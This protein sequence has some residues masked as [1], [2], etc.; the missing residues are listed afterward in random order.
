MDRQDSPGRSLTR[1]EPYGRDQFLSEMQ[2]FFGRFKVKEDVRFNV[3]SAEFAEGSED[4]GRAHLK[5]FVVGRDGQGRREWLKGTAHVA[6]TKVGGENWR[7]REL[8]LETLASKVSRTDLFSEVALPAGVA[9]VFPTFGTGKNQG[10]VSHGAAVA[11]VNGDGLLDLAV[12]GVDRN[13]LYVNDGA[14]GFRDTSSES[15]I[16]FAP[17]GSGVL[18][19]DYDND[20]DSDLFMA[21]VG[22]QVLFE[23]RW[24]PDGELRFWDVSEKAGVDRSAVGFS[25]V[26]ADVNADGYPDIYVAS[27]NHYGTVM[28]DSWLRATN[29][30]PNL[31][32]INGGDG[33]F[34]EAGGAWNVGDSRWSYA[35]GFVRYRSRR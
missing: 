7:L 19:L 9:G 10:F 8:E 34:Q 24:I 3:K 6:V 22:P 13:R 15:L 16:E 21:A 5:F 32:F 18:F 14:G 4:T 23:N 31:L 20:G 27:Y 30:T 29:G 28:P 1:P 11:D 25:A 33:T 17:P 12:S 26:S 35:A 2:T